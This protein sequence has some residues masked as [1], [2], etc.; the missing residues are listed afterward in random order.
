MR[1]IP[2]ILAALAVLGLAACNNHSSSGKKQASA[3]AVHSVSGTVNLLKPRTLSSKATMQIQLVDSSLEGSQPLATKTI[4][5]VEQMPV[6]FTLDFDRAKIRPADI[7]L[8]KV[9]LVDG[10]RTFSMPIQ[11]PVITQGAPTSQVKIELSANQTPEEKLMSEYGKLKQN[12]GGYQISNG[13]QLEKDMSRGWQTFRDKTT[14]KI[15]FVRENVDYGKKKG[16]EDNDFA[17]KGG[18]PWFVIVRHKTSQQSRPSD[19]M[20]AGWN[21]D[22]KLLIHDHVVSGKTSPLSAGDAAKLKQQAED[23]LKLARLRTPAP[24]KKH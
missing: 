5:P 24:K 9:N 23:M 7:Y 12:L 18:K 11:T 14:E 3:K 22:G 15:V 10:E 2:L 8:V 13:R 4:S 17:Y 20:R 1:R 6:H 16:F 21:A 19:I